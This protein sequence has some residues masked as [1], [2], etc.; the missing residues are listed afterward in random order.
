MASC[1]A[2]EVREPYAT[3]FLQEKE[4]LTGWP[5]K[6]KNMDV[7]TAVLL[8]IDNTLTPPRRQLTEPMAEILKRLCIP[9]HV[10]AGSHLALLQEQFFESL[11]TFGFRKQFDA[12]L[13]NGAIH[14]RCDYSK[15]MSIEM[16]SAFNIRDYL[17]DVDYNFLIEILT[18]TLEL[19]EFLL[20]PP[21]KVM[22]ERI[23]FRGSMINFCTI[24][25]PEQESAESRHNRDNFVKFDNTT[26]YRQKLMDHLKRELSSLI[27]KRQ[28]TITLGGQ[29]SFDIGITTQD[30]TNAVRTLLQN[31][32][33]RLVFIGD[34]LFEG[35]NDASIREFVKNWPSTSPCPVETVQV[36]SWKETIEKLYE[37][38]FVG[39]QTE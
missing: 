1:R 19:R 14:Y 34:A 23:I 38:E 8:D 2:C 36:S 28:L 29:T 22:G 21:L 13:S 27:N 17:G 24:G 32:T 15:G 30:K 6:G 7:K 33:K 16:V 12:F 10:A 11:Y 4:D 39:G 20:L 35:G 26:Q 9:F 5:V 37:F 25:R 18:K 31:G 3:P